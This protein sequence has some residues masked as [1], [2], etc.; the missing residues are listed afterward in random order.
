MTLLVKKHYV[1]VQI[2][3]TDDEQVAFRAAQVAPAAIVPDG[4]TQ[5]EGTPASL[6]HDA[7]SQDTVPQNANKVK[8]NLQSLPGKHPYTMQVNIDK[9]T[10]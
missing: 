10:T 9:N 2:K 1:H 7:Q 4:N 8:V 6:E 3:N 5:P